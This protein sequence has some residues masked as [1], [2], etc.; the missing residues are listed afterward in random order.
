MEGS[1]GTRVEKESGKRECRNGKKAARYREGNPPETKMKREG[2]A[3][4]ESYKGKEGET[5]SRW[6]RN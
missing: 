4:E 1:R 3:S 2:R 5:A 6:Y